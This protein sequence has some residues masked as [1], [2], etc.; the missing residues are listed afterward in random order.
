MWQLSQM[1]P[2]LLFAVHLLWQ[3]SFKGIIL[4]IYSSNRLSKQS[5]LRRSIFRN[6]VW[7]NPYLYVIWY[8]RFK[9]FC[10]WKLNQSQILTKSFKSQDQA[11]Y[12]LCILYAS[13]SQQKSI[14]KGPYMSEIININLNTKNELI[15]WLLK[16]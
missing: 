14:G 3:K 11:M 4:F 13:D 8:H 12:V 7:K 16:K 2:F 9:I 5:D 1:H 15:R 10:L 6:I